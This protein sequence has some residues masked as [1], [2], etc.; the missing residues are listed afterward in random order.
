[1]TV[2]RGSN[3]FLKLAKIGAKVV[4]R[5]VKTSISNEIVR[6][7]LALNKL[8]VGATSTQLLSVIPAPTRS[9]K[10]SKN[11]HELLVYLDTKKAALDQLKLDTAY[12]DDVS[13]E[14]YVRACTA[15]QRYKPALNMLERFK[16]DELSIDL[17]LSLADLYLKTSQY[18]LAEDVLSSINSEFLTGF[19]DVK[20]GKL[21]I[22]LY[23]HTNRFDEAVSE[24]D[25]ILVYGIEYPNLMNHKY[26]ILMNCLNLDA[27]KKVIETNFQDN[28]LSPPVIYRYTDF[29]FKTNQLSSLKIL[30]LTLQSR[31]PGDKVI[32]MKAARLA[33]TLGDHTWLKRITDL[34]NEKKWYNIEFATFVSRISANYEY[35]EETQQAIWDHLD[36][37]WDRTKN[38]TVNTL[39]WRINQMAQA[40]RVNHDKFAIE[41][42]T[43]VINK[44]PFVNQAYNYRGLA[45]SA[46]GNWE[47][48]RR[49]LEKAISLNPQNLEANNALFA[50][51]MR[52]PRGKESAKRLS[53]ILFR[54]NA[55]IPRFSM[56]LPDGRGPFYDTEA[57][58]AGMR[59]DD[60]VKSIRCR[61]NQPPN[62]YL[63]D[64]YPDKYRTFEDG[65]FDKVKKEAVAIIGQDGVADE[66]RWAQYYGQ[67]NQYF[68]N[69]EISCEPRLETIFRR[70][71]P[72]YKFTSIKRRWPFVESTDETIRPEIHEVSFGAKVTKDFLDKVAKKDEVMFIEEVA[73]RHWLTQGV[74]GPADEGCGNGAYLKPLPARKKYW[75]DRFKADS[76]KTV[77]VGLLWRSSLR[78][79]V[80]NGHYLKLE[81][82][83]PVVHSSPNVK[84]VS[85]QHKIDEGERAICAANGIEV[86]DDFDWFNDFEEIAAFTSNLDLVIGISSLPFELATAV[87]T[88][89]YLYAISPEGRY[90]RLGNS[91]SDRDKM[92]YNCRVF[93]G[94][95]KEDGFFQEK[96]TM[97]SNVNSQII[98]A[99]Q[100]AK[101]NGNRFIA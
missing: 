32:H 48:A 83:L 93:C 87:G 94:D 95:T 98:R 37:Q 57:Y 52:R 58:K 59:S 35:L 92:T 81:D 85:I 15:T 1:M 99:L 30:L 41:C 78:N 101:K 6:R 50:L 29:L 84:F 31:M 18:K 17:K 39:S 2:Q 20:R 97:I 9:A 40:C 36:A 24:I 55:A 100:V 43:N 33:W 13:V 46:L 64:L 67:L 11:P 54:R 56:V 77:T 51:E 79:Q 76:K 12:S 88:P 75:K 45:H 61:N 21:L 70:S 7:H 63:S 72:K 47:E 60:Y 23:Q 3:A 86:F 66:V 27:A 5:S 26:D 42:A 14:E 65:A 96:R 22:N 89:A 71:F 49:D 91:T 34:Y 82:M 8:N 4:P 53:E 62:R 68:K 25:R 80:R 10:V 44:Y 16:K 28:L 38:V 73:Y 90:N 74:S 19:G 69:V